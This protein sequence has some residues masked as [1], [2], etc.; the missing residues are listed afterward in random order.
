[1]DSLLNYGALGIF[2]LC[3][4]YAVQKLS[5]VAFD[6]ISLVKSIDTNLTT[7][8]ATHA[9]TMETHDATIKLLHET[10]TFERTQ[11]ITCRDSV[12]DMLLDH[13]KQSAQRQNDILV[14]S[15]DIQS[16]IEKFCLTC[17]RSN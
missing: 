4:I 14:M 6:S 7:L 12:V 10:I 11:S 17:K 15:K 8:V 3:L 9:K 2:C 5:S 1:V 16:N 13:E